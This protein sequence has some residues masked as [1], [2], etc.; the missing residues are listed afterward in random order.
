MISQFT[1]ASVNM[2]LV[3]FEEVTYLPHQLFQTSETNL[4]HDLV[5]THTLITQELYQEKILYIIST[6]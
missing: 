6:F 5:N 4:E 1:C 2:I 3:K